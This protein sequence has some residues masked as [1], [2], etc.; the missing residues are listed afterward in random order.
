[1][2]SGVANLASAF[3][4]RRPWSL[5]IAVNAAILAF[6]IVTKATGDYP[7]IQYTYLLVTY[8]FGFA[9][10]ALLGS[11]L[12][13]FEDKV[14][15]YEVWIIGG[16]AWLIT[17]A[18]FVAVFKRI[19]GFAGDRIQLFVFTFGSPFFFKNFYHTVGFFDIYGCLWALAVFLLPVN[20]LFPLVVAAG[21]VVL[22]LIHHLQFLL[23][24][25]VIG[26]I[27]VVRYYWLRPFSTIDVMYGGGGALAVCAA[28]VICITAGNVPVPPEVLHDYMRQRAAD[29]LTLVN[30][31]IWYSTI[32][33]EIHRTAMMFPKNA[34]RIPIFLVL[35][36]LH[37]PLIRFMRAIL[38]GV[39]NPAHRMLAIAAMAGISLGYLCI[40]VVVYDYAR[41]WCSWAVCMMLVLFAL[42]LLQSRSGKPQPAFATP[43][44]ERANV[45]LGWTVT[46]IPRVG[47]QIPF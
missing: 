19:F 5:M 25:P 26:F 14:R 17:V 8:H 20:M 34:P 18:L 12:A 10:R 23:Y 21:C 32:G 16:A 29:P 43:Q 44:T 28:F 6:V 27:A 30:L 39:P 2:T 9:K 31:H 38:A 15:I 36:A 35:I 1:M 42:A 13:L 7:V 24:V 37:W 40:F 22:V 3:W 41:W 46:A 4:S 11:I 45:A 33:E 47:L